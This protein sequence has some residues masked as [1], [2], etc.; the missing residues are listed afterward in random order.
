MSIRKSSQGP[1]RKAKLADGS[2]IGF[3]VDTIHK[4]TNRRT[5]I[6]EY[7]NKKMRDAIAKNLH[8]IEKRLGIKLLRTNKGDIAQPEGSGYFGTA[9][10]LEDGKIFKVSLDETEGGSSLFWMESQK[11]NSRLLAGSAKVFDVFQFK[12]RKDTFYCSVREYVG[13]DY[14]PPSIRL[15]LGKYVQEFHG[16]CMGPDEDDASFSLERSKI[17]IEQLKK[18]APGIAYCLQ[19]AWDK[20]LPML[21]PT[22][23]NVGIR[24]SN[25]KV[26]SSRKKY[27]SA[28][29]GDWVVFDFGGLS[30]E[31]FE[32]VNKDSRGRKTSI[33]GILRKYCQRVDVLK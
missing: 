7:P 1:V 26:G 28:K 2:M 17:A 8:K 16:F 18:T 32:F 11:K 27:K 25:L 14:I 21:D 9:F 33:K 15:Y 29:V 5:K 19:W 30:F 3:T 10:L 24:V 31:C 4:S 23:N 6:K 12:E 22:E 13:I 20:G